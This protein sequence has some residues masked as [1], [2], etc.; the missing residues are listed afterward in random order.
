MIAVDAWMQRP[1]GFVLRGG[2]AADVEPWMALFGNAYVGHLWVH[3]YVAAFVVVGAPTRRSPRRRTAT[4]S[5]A[6]CAP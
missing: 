1:G 4:P 3:M 6:P 2:R 5:S